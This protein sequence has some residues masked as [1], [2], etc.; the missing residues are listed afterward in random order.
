MA[1]I[2]QVSFDIRPDQM[3]ELE[4][5][6]SLERVLGYLRT[7]LPGEPGF[8]MAR[9]MSSLDDPEKTQVI[10][11]STWENW[12][13]FEAHRQSELSENKVLI[14]FAPHVLLEHL[15]IRIYQEVA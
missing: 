9:A 3:N 12:D 11:E 8:V 5:G 7:R 1:Y 15:T 10:F 6:A 4:I 13:E 2:H 14:E